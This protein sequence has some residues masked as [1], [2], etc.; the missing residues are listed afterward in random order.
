MQKFGPTR[1][2]NEVYFNFTLACPRFTAPFA[3]LRCFLRPHFMCGPVG[4]TLRSL[5]TASNFPLSTFCF[6]AFLSLLTPFLVFNC[7]PFSFW[8]HFLFVTRS[9]FSSFSPASLQEEL[10]FS[11]GCVCTKTGLRNRCDFRSEELFWAS[12]P[13]PTLP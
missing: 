9:A 12:N 8:C 11:T 2:A 7:F 3:K 10:N 6:F 13:L 5:P 1:T 4:L